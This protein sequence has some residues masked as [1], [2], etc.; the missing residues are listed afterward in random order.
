MLGEAENLPFASVS[1]WNCAPDNSTL[2][3]YF[4]AL[5]TAVSS[6]LISS[7]ELS[8]EVQRYT[9]VNNKDQKFTFNKVMKP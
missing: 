1:T 3:F 7:T 5:I 8:Y 9:V 6:L 4:T 2:F